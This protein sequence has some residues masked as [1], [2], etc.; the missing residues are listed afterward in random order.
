MNALIAFQFS[1]VISSHWTVVLSVGLLFFALQL[2]L[3]TRFYRWIRLYEKAVG[4]LYED[5]EQGGNGRSSIELMPNQFAWLKWVNTNFAE[6]MTT[7]GNFTRDEVFQE[8]DSRIASSSDYLL[9]QRLGVMAPLVGVI[10][11][12]TGFWWVELPE[13]GD[14]KLSEMLAV[15][16]PLVAG[17]GTGAILAL[18]NQWLL[19]LVGGKTESLR[20]AAR[21]WFDAAVWNTVGLDTQEATV[22]AISAMEHMATSISESADQQTQNA[23]RLAESTAMIRQASGEFSEMVQNFGLEIKGMPDTLADLGSATAASTKALEELIP[24]GKRAVAGL[25]VS[26]SAFRT[27]I[28]QDFIAVAGLY[29]TSIKDFS[30]SVSR[31]NEST[32]HLQSGSCDLQDTAKAQSASF[33]KMNE[34]LRQQVLPAHTGLSSAVN[35]LT[36][37]MHL[38]EGMVGT[39][40]SRVDTV[41]AEF[42]QITGD[43]QSSVNAFREAVDGQFTSAAREHQQNMV[44]LGHSSAQLQQ[45]AQALSDGSQEFTELLH[46]QSEFSKQIGPVQTAFRDTVQQL[47]D[48]GAVLQETVCS[49]I[50]PSQGSLRKAS[51]SLTDSAD[52]LAKFIEQGLGPATKRLT[53]LHQTVFGIEQT[54]QEMQRFLSAGGNIDR[55]STSLAQVADV[56][57]AIA[58]LPQQILETLNQHVP[59]QAEI[60]ASRGG[61]MGWLRGRRV[62]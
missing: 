59:D 19:H 1:S 9:L 7:P 31:I 5:I 39:L 25:D 56:A 14:P 34:T 24:I 53:E 12:V 47:S 40:S 11:T 58:A 10:L 49:D 41:A 3:C 48:A 17:V 50:S 20:M 27:A 30:D 42:G 4:A 45:A 61:L 46:Q 23:T 52:V 6:G 2:A 29:H 21:T 26:V 38:L 13:S 33:Q 54:M 43:L 37:R 62:E 32:L 15:V 22:H 51:A 35:Q 55:L 44:S 28:E 8:L 16:T 36:H 18:I 57:V 60:A